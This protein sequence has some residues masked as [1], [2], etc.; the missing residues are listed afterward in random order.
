MDAHIHMYGKIICIH[1]YI[2][3]Y[4]YLYVCVCRAKLVVRRGLLC[5]A[6]CCSALR[7]LFSSSTIVHIYVHD[8]ISGVLQCVVVCCFVVQ[9]V[10]ACYSVLSSCLLW[11]HIYRQAETSSVLQCGTVCCN[12]SQCVAVCCSMTHVHPQGATSACTAR[13][14]GGGRRAPMRG[15]LLYSS[16]RYICIYIHKCVHSYLCM[17]I[18]IYIDINTFMHVYTITCMHTR[19][20]LRVCSIIDMCGE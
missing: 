19:A 2:Y 12:V 17:Y 1:I 15:E 7:V 11:I 10:A 5:D 18:Y 14:G 3:I 8:E 13:R 20:Q 16:H 4:T 6:V 9:C